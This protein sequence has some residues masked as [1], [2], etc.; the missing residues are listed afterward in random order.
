MTIIAVPRNGTSVSIP[1]DLRE[2]LAVTAQPAEEECR[3]P[4]GCRCD[5]DNQ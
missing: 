4:F 3:C 1:D 5:H 2:L